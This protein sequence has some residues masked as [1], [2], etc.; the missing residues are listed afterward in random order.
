MADSHYTNEKNR[1]SSWAIANNESIVFESNT[2]IIKANKVVHYVFS[3]SNGNSLYLI[4][5]VS[6]TLLTLCGFMFYKKKGKMK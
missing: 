5:T 4:V 1:L 6:L 2:F 3:S